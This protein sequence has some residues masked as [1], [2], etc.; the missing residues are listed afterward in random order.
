[1][2]P[3]AR[4][5]CVP[6]RDC[7]AP[8]NAPRVYA[9]TTPLRAGTFRNGR[10]VQ[11][12]KRLAR[13][14]AQT[15]QRLGH[16]LLAR[17]RLP[18]NQHG[19]GARR[20]QPDEPVQAPA[21]AQL[22][23]TIS[24]SATNEAEARNATGSV[25]EPAPLIPAPRAV[26][27]GPGPQP[28]W[29]SATTLQRL[30][31]LRHALVR[32]ANRMQQLVSPACTACAIPAS[33]RAA[34]RSAARP[35]PPYICAHLPGELAHLQVRQPAVHHQGL[36]T[37]RLHLGHGFCTAGPLQSHVQR[38]SGQLP[39][40]NVARRTGIPAGHHHQTALFS[41]CWLRIPCESW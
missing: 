4:P 39:S 19:G 21:S 24:G 16:N 22:A 11:H 37:L 30:P 18:F 25:A 14:R 29:S 28:L 40:A 36:G 35:C 20:D 33:H 9:R 2:C 41:T 32:L 6:V 26:A 23:P 38:I 8:V 15:M 27:P 1:M 17:A 5:R 7:T 34:R 3:R 10:A 12:H 31:R 13:T